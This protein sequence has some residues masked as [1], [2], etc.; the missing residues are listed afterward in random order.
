MIKVKTIW[1]KQYTKI[2]NRIA[3]TTTEKQQIENKMITSDRGASIYTIN[4]NN[5]RCLET[6]NKETK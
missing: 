3:D 1:T 5:K 4:R 2:A 6:K